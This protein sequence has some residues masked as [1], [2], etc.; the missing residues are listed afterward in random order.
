MVLVD[1]R[2]G[3]ANRIPLD[4]GMPAGMVSDLDGAGIQAFLSSVG[5]RST[6]RFNFDPLETKTGR[7]GIVTSFSSAG[8]TAF[9]H[10]LKP[11]VGAPGGEILSSTLPEFAGAPFAPFDGTS[12][13]S[14]HVAGAAAL[15]L[16]RH[17]GWSVRQV[18]SALVS[19]AGGAWQNTARTDEASVLVSGG[20]LTNVHEADAPAIFTEPAML[21]FGD[22]NVNRGAQRRSRLLSISDAGG[23]AGI[24]T[25]EVRPQSASTG[26][27]LAL[28]GLVT[29]GPGGTTDIGVAAVAS[30]DAAAGDNYGFIVLRHGTTS[31]RVPYAFFVTRPALES[32][33]PTPGRLR[34]QFGG[35]TLG[36]PSRVNVYR[37][38]SSPFGHPPGYFGPPMAEVGAERLYEVPHL[39]RPV[40]NLG[41]AVI[42]ATRGSLINPWLLGAPDENSVQ[43]QAATPVNVNALTF[44]FRLPIGAAAAVFPSLKR[45]WVAVDSSVDEYTGRPLSG[46][47]VL[48]YWVN[49][50][51]PPTVNLVTRRVAAGR[52]TIVV[53]AS[54]RGA[55]VNPLSLVLSYRRALIGASVYDV[56]SGLAV[57]VLPRAAPRLPRGRTNAIVMAS[58]YQESKNVQTFGRNVLPNTRFRSVR[59]RVVRGTTVNWLLPQRGAC[60]RGRIQLV[61]VA[62]STRRIASV[63]FFDGARRIGVD[64]S[65]SA[66][67]YSVNWAARRARRGRHVLRA[68]VSTRGGRRAVARRPV[69]VCR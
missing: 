20:G 43:G 3:E 8:P 14:P 67:L 58:D 1:N 16:Q 34:R 57:F 46:R 49:D 68:V 15:L 19:T 61:V 36:G 65:G 24:W 56:S 54:D 31:R 33:E 53:R 39:T 45:F 25:V 7:S 50:L 42:A 30:A 60:V 12:M 9:E 4:L 62:G 26:A 27:S 22:L 44:D 48:R 32:Y 52:P 69:R 17:P 29:V 41:V 37:W 13:A 10:R 28:P 38:P 23:G 40:V 47:Y 35:S 6:A 63:R 18:K 11:D 55:G 66:G 2:P 21:S 64:R 51:R 5:G 59:L